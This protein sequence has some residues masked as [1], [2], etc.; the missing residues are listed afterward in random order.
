MGGDGDP[1]EQHGGVGHDPVEGEQDAIAA[2]GQG[3]AVE[4][5]AVDPAPLPA[6]AV[7]VRP[8]QRDDRVRHG[9]VSE[10][11]VVVAGP[12]RAGDV[13]AAEQP[14]LVES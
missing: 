10:A 2:G 8:G 7:P 12:L 3:G 13:A 9:D 14:A 6:P 4:V 1:A 5:L 11:A